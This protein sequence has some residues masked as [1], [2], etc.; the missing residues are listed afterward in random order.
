VARWSGLAIALVDMPLVWWLQVVD[1]RVS[2]SPSGVAGFTLGVLCMQVT[3]STVSLHAAMP[4][5]AAAVGA[6]V[7]WD[8][9]RRA[10]VPVGARLFSVICLAMAGGVCSFLVQHLRQLL[11]LVAAEEQKRAKLG[12]Y[13]SPSVAAQLERGVISDGPETRNV[14]VMFTDIRDFTA[15]SEKLTPAQVVEMLNGYHDRMVAVIF[16]HGGTLDKFIG[17]GIMAYF[18]APL[19]DALHAQHAVD[20]ALDMGDELAALNR[21]RTARG[22]VALAIGVGIHTGEAVIGDI[23]SPRHRLEFTA[24][25]DA[26]NTA[27]RIE[28][29]TKQHHAQVLAS[30]TTRDLAN[31]GV[32]WT[33]APAVAVK[34]KAE[35]VVTYLPARA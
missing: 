20:C 24:I 17:D 13:F 6:V 11:T 21:E 2:S 4:L 18:G 29:L 19:P 25:G 8:L 30:Q 9:Q 16:K 35:P 33:A 12:R 7:E 22:E 26:V 3:L 27:S 1:E 31:A 32:S 23:G 34:G 14:T 5:V 10:D 15:L 28:G